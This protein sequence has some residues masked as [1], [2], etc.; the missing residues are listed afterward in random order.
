MPFQEYHDDYPHKRFT[1]GFAGRPGGP[2]F[3][4]N[5]VNNS[6]NHGP[7]G[8]SH[9]DLHEEADPCFATLVGGIPI[10]NELNRIPTNQ[11]KGSLL[12]H[13]VGIVDSRVIAKV[14]IE[15]DDDDDDDQ[16]DE[17]ED[18][19]GGGGGIDLPSAGPS[20]A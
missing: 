9:H 2:D 13:H 4:I 3:Y 12:L 17:Q 18:D 15:A 8:Q 14:T 10:L 19:Q 20:P 1:V 16:H 6:E 7:G 11:D 5:K